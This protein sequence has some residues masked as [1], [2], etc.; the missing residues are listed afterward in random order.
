MYKISL[1]F[2]FSAL[3]LRARTNHSNK[4][5]LSNSLD[6]L[7][8]KNSTLFIAITSGP[9]HGQLRNAAR[10]T[11][12]LPCILDPNCDYRYFI[13][14]VSISESL[15]EERI[16]HKDMIFRDFCSL[17]E[18]HPADVNYG[19]IGEIANPDDKL[20]SPASKIPDYR[21]R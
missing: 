17:M 6:T 18:R 9:R 4:R 8:M 19:N 10:E 11:W 20:N 14:T 7:K 1:V 12:L 15:E 5:Y 2:I 21:W 16:K 3:H 13:D